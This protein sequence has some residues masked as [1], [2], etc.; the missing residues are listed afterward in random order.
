MIKRIIFDIDG[1]LITGIDFRKCVEKTLKLYDAYSKE[2]VDIFLTNIPNYEKV[3]NSYDRLEY[4]KFFSKKL[5]IYLNDNFLKIFFEQLKSAI[6]NYNQK[7][8]DMLESLNNYEL[9]LLSNFFKESQM[10]RLKNM[11]IDKYFSEYYGEKLIKP[12][13]FAYISSLGNNL[14]SE[15]VIVGDNLKLD[16]EI[17][18]KLG[19]NTIYINSK[20]DNKFGVTLRSV[21][22][23]TP[24]LIKRM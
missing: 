15:C 9:V 20:N 10:N 17:P 21:E 16:I 23:I 7:I 4:L 22:D 1:T 3:H 12:N 11:K 6:P 5:N 2:N 13:E 18:S 19:L 8:I 14:P 24:Q